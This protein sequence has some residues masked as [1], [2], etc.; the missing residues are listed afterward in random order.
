MG[1][2]MRWYLHQSV[3]PYLGDVVY[4]LDRWCE[5][6]TIRSEATTSVIVLHILGLIKYSFTSFLSVTVSTLQQ[7]KVHF[8]LT[9]SKVVQIFT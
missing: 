4:R 2:S 3:F 1:V 6:V 5:H 7:R 8:I 9:V